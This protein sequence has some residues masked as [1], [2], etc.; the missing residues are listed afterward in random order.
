MIQLCQSSDIQDPGAKGFSDDNYNI[1]VVHKD[2]QFYG[3]RNSCP[4]IGVPL[5]WMPDEFLDKEQRL[6]M[7]ANHG[8]EFLIETGEC[9]AG[10][11]SGQS[12]T[13]VPVEVKDGVLYAEI[14]E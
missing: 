1:L 2:G 11:C 8:A 5:E 9:I 12:L 4:H 13:A 10:P 6:I 14:S 3:Y 7:C